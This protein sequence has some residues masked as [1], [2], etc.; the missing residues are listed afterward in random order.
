M[1]R[2]NTIQKKMIN[3]ALAE[4]YHPTAEQIYKHI[5]SKG[6]IFSLPTVYRNLNLMV[7]QGELVKLVTEES[8]DRFDSEVKTHYHFRCIKCGNIIDVPCEL[9]QTDLNKKFE[10]SLGVEVLKHNIQFSGVCNNCK[11]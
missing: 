1:E 11:S 10:K 9:Y 5:K 4:L 6:Y 2:R 3:E 7:E 8:T